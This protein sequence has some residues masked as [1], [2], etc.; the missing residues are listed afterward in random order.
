MAYV[1]PDVISPL[2][3][4]FEWTFDNGQRPQEIQ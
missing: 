3:F 2:P 4:A 1:S